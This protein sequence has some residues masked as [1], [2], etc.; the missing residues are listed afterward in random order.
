[1][2]GNLLSMLECAAILQIGCD[3]GRPESMAAGRVGET[4]L[5]RPALDHPQHVIGVHPVLRQP[6]ALTNTGKQPTFLV[7]FDAGGADPVIKI[8]TQS[9]MARYLVALAAFLVQPQ[10]PTLFVFEIIADP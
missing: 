8:F 2:C 7:G 5:L 3:P 4:G 10:P 1:M 9:V 6:V